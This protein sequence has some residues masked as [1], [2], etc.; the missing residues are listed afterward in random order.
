MRTLNAFTLAQNFHFSPCQAPRSSP[1]VEMQFPHLE[2]D[3]LISECQS[4]FP[5]VWHQLVRRQNHWWHF[6]SSPVK[7]LHS[8]K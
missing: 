2:S 1:E 4:L 6:L 3:L 5:G 8:E 7:P